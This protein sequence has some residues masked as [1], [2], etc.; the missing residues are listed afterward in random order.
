MQLAQP[1]AQHISKQP[2][3]AIP[4][5]L[6]VERDDEEVRGFQRLQHLLGR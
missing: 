1:Q 2:V 4:A 6:R 5:P 3:V